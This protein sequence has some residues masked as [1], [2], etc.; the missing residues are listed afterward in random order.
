[1]HEIVRVLE[2]NDDIEAVGSRL[3][4][5]GVKFLLELL[6]DIVG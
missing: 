3:E 5:R 6:L 1:V 2:S 4:Y